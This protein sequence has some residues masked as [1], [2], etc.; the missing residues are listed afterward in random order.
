MEMKN[1]KIKNVRMK[2][3]KWKNEKWK[4]KMEK[5]KNGFNV[6]LLYVMFFTFLKCVVMRLL[7]FY[8]FNVPNE[9]FKALIF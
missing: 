1:G 2:N 3:K 8:L 4:M 6:Y 7:C 5:S 9:C